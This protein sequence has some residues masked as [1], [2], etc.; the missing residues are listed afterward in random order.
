MTTTRF[1]TILHTQRKA[2]KLIYVITIFPKT[3]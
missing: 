1:P 3:C 2:N